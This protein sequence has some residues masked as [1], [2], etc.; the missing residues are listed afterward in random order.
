MAGPAEGAIPIAHFVAFHLSQIETRDIVAVYL[1][2]TDPAN[3]ALPF[4][5]GRGFDQDV[6][7]KKVLVTEDIF[8]SGGSAQRSVEAVRR[9]GGDV[10]GVAGI[11]NR[12][13]V[14]PEQVGQAPRLT[15]LTD[16]AGIAMIAWRDLT[17][18]LCDKLE[19]L[20]TDIGKGKSWLETPLGKA[21]LLKGGTTLG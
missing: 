6:L 21:W 18:P 9:A 20:R 12:G 5:L 10:I 19:P 7:G 14:T 3:K 2:P 1:E 17:C 13:R 11:A 15:A 16:M 4:Y 8:T